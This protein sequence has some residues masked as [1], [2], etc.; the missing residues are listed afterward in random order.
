[1]ITDSS[2]GAL[3]NV[4]I[5]LKGD[6]KP[7][8]LS[9]ENGSYNLTVAPGSYEISFQHSGYV[10][11]KKKIQVAANER[12]NITITLLRD[13]KQLEEVFV[14]AQ[15]SRGLTSASI[16]DRDA[17]RVLQPS[18]FAD[19]MEL[20]PGGRS[21]APRLTEVNPI[22]L[23]ESP[24]DRNGN[25]SNASDISSLGTG[26]YIDGAPLITD[27]DMQS[28][29]G[30]STADANGPRNITGKGV[31]MR[32]IPTDQIEKVEV[33][34]GIPSVEYSDLTSGAVLITRKKGEKPL[35]A[36]I[37]AD[38]FGKLFSAGKGF[39]FSRRKLSLNTDIDFL[40]A[41][42]DP[43]KNFVNYKRLT[44][45][46]RTDKNWEKGT[47]LLNWAAAFD[48]SHNIDDE[49]PDPDN[50]L[51]GID[52]YKSTNNRYAFNNKLS[53][54]YK[55]RR[56][57][58]SA[59]LSANVSYSD[60]LID[61]TKWIQPRTATVLVNTTAPGV[62][63][64]GFLTTGYAG[65]LI[66]EGKPVT[67]SG[68][69]IINGNY[70]TGSIFHRLK[71]G[72]EYRY[73][74]NF[75]RGQVYDLN[76]PL[77]VVSRPLTGSADRPRAFKDIPALQQLSAYVE[78]VS[79]VN[80]QNHHFMLS[81]GLRGFS[82][83][84]INRRYAISG[85]LFF[86]PRI[87][88]KWTLPALLVN[89][90]SLYITLGTGYGVLTKLPTT[91]DLYPVKNYIDL[92]QLNYYHNNPAFRTANAV[93]YIFD[94]TNYQLQPAI[95][96]KWELN[97]DLNYDHYRLSVTYFKEKMNSGFRG[98]SVY[99]ALAYR[100]YDNA[101]INP[102][103]LTTRPGVGDF[104]YRDVKEY[105]GY[106]IPSNGS[107][108]VKEGV[109]YQLNT[110]RFR[111]IN[112]RFTLNGAWFR[113]N[114]SNSQTSYNVISTSV[115]TNGNIRQYVGRYEEDNGTFYEQFNTNLTA[116]VYIKTL[117]M[118]IAASFQSRW[119]ISSQMAYKS[120]TPVTYLDI[121]GT[122]YVY[123]EESIRRDPDIKFLDRQYS[124]EIFKKN[125]VPIDLQSNIKVSKGLKNGKAMLSMFVNK[126]FVYTPN[127]YNENGV[128]IIRKGIDNS[129]YFGMELNLNL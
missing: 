129:P 42:S 36:R 68:K 83:P 82:S 92:I 12:L 23:R 75:G 104:A 91:D 121:N 9:A 69:L 90:K 89:D 101:S 5:E 60:N 124:P 49:K 7:T 61:L 17:M 47:R 99:Q 27:A 62:H 11:Q 13:P 53:L 45:S 40:D 96:H 20:L 71:I 37:K 126:M 117:N 57:I 106:T 25:Y 64:A 65:H 46:I 103:T 118:Y 109:E 15:E 87:N 22:R 3:Q 110:K 98:T 6:R 35:T 116:D 30:F 102:D 112:T 16:I 125:T 31:D 44:A 59:E 100:K 111:G 97:A 114:Y 67:G 77:D 41:V 88:F 74:K 56:F 66:V 70:H 28:T 54:R 81:A 113:T 29:E 79:D 72:S 33:I 14:T 4:V 128:Y 80:L 63:D 78:N 122:E 10:T 105:H 19:L 52:K 108:L 85:K 1:M 24:I 58:K 2:G 34:R 115:I 84:G 50:S 120:S 76:F 127:Y 18:S 26:F 8:V 107:G 94:A 32:T 95:N 123:N 48:L 21:R 43:T 119:F 39:Y 86:D 55:E 38:G 51:A 93:T 73:S